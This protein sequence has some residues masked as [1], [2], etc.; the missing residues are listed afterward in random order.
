MR[1]SVKFNVFIQVFVTG[2]HEI[3]TVFCAFVLAFYRKT[4]NEMLD[5]MYMRS[6]VGNVYPS[7]TCVA[8]ISCFGHIINLSEW[9]ASIYLS[10]LKLCHMTGRYECW[11]RQNTF[12]VVK[13]FLLYYDANVCI[14]I[15]MRALRPEMFLCTKTVINLSLA[16]LYFWAHTVLGH[17]FLFHLT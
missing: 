14:Y 3:F 9:D 2:L 12:E 15:S 6:S 5:D 1:V 13:R 10:K 11:L 4:N 17:L 8:I 7:I 16:L